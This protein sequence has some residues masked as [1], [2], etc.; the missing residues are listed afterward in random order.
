MFIRF[1][2]S[3]LAFEEGS[4]ACAWGAGLQLGLGLN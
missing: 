3:G 1:N 4:I 2:V